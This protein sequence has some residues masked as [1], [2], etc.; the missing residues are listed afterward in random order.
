[1]KWILKGTLSN[2]IDKE[3][4][5][6]PSHLLQNRSLPPLMTVLAQKMMQN[7][8]HRVASIAMLPCQFGYLQLIHHDTTHHT[9]TRALQP[10]SELQM[11]EATSWKQVHHSC[12]SCKMASVVLFQ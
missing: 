5:Q 8:F 6:N 9:H 10:F 3:C 2:A 7:G 1:M 11:S 12:C 4:I